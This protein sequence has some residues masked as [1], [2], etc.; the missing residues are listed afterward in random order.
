MWLLHSNKP[1]WIVGYIW[2]YVGDGG[3]MS[4][5]FVVGY[6]L[7]KP[8][9]DVRLAALAFG[10]AIWLCLIGTI[11]LAP[12]GSQM[13]FQLTPITVSLSL[14]GHIIYGLSIGFLYPIFIPQGA[15]AKLFRLLHTWYTGNMTEV[16][17]YLRE[18]NQVLREQLRIASGRM[19]ESSKIVQLDTKKQPNDK[20]KVARSIKR[21]RRKR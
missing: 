8:R 1:D 20:R 17:A 19:E 16:N 15:L 10:I 11:L 13:L 9:L 2:R 12:H 7:L 14:L 3:L 6:C 21:R 4:T 5:A 18:E